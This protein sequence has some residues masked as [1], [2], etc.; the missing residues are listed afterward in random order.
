MC[1][2]VCVREM[3]R[4]G[5]ERA[6]LLMTMKRRR[7]LDKGT[8]ATGQQVRVQGGNEG[9]GRGALSSFTTLSFVRCIT[10]ETRLN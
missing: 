6:L 4:D 7:V 5:C 9:E 10:T 1:V 2:C 8:I 3:R